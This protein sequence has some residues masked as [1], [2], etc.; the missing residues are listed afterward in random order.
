M[1]KLVKVLAALLLAL[2]IVLYFYWLLPFWG[3]PFNAAR[4]SNPVLTPPWALECWLWEDDA[5]TAERVDE[6]LAGYK[7]HDIPVRSIIID[8]PWSSRYNDFQVDT[9]HYPNPQQWFSRLQNDGYR[10]V[11]WMTSMV[12]S[13]SKDTAIRESKAFYQ[14]ARDSGYLIGD[15]L[16]VKWWKGSGGFIDYTNPEALEWWRGMQQQLFDWGIDGWKLD[17]TATFFSSKLF[18][19]LAPY[20][21][22]FKGL[23]TT[24]GYM[25]QYYRQEYFH[26]LTQNPEF[27]TLARSIDMPWAHPEGFAPFDAAPVTWVGD[28]QHTW[29]S[30]ES[31]HGAATPDK[32]LMREVDQGIEEAVRYI[33][34][35]ARLGYN[36]IGSDVAGFS[37]AEIPPR[38]YI[39]WA[40]F[41]TFCGLFMNGGHGERALWKRSKEELDIIR[42]FSWLH[43]E[44][45]PYMYSYVA[46]YANGG[47]K[48]LMRPIKNGKYEYLFGENLLVAPIY[49]DTLRRSVVLPR[50]DWRYFFEDQNVIHGPG[51]INRDFPLHEFPVFVRDGA[52]IPMHVSRPY[53]GFGDEADDGYVTLLI[54]PSRS[55]RF[56]L[57][58]PDKS[59]ATTVVSELSES[60]LHISLRGTKMPHI[61][62]IQL[63]KKPSQVLLDGERLANN[64]DWQFEN[65]KLVIRTKDYAAGEYH[66]ILDE[67]TRVFSSVQNCIWDGTCARKLRFT[68][69]ATAQYRF[70]PAIVQL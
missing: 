70:T 59:G 52:I 62:R 21:R 61:L 1:K 56:T 44:L 51:T 57:H 38:L 9:T 69:T 66:I 15:G 29:Q 42:T 16:Q 64:K 20:S 58:H 18:G 30:G 54:Y 65:N 2:V 49:E 68:L 25:D 46:D 47:K 53:T 24:R 12:N 48:P 13:N 4:H 19:L 11:L 67:T 43:T 31:L 6:L 23:M 37:G 22:T 39:R 63:D 34:Q 55:S 50:G 35:S 17:G 8:S 26:G 60:A 28:Q 36:I 45:I 5:G 33:L 3:M 14:A 40:Q 27:I 7:K 10:V 32:D 41:S